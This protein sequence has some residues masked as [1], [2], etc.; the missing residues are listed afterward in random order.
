MAH[1]GAAPALTN[2]KSE[3]ISLINSGINIVTGNSKRNEK[4]PNNL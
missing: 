2:R 3:I 1:Y 4:Q